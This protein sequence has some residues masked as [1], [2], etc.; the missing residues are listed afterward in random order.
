MRQWQ[1]EACRPSAGALPASCVGTPEVCHAHTSRRSSLQCCPAPRRCGRDA[2][3]RGATAIDLAHRHDAGRHPGHRRRARPGHRRHPLHGLY[4]LRPVGGMGPL[5]GHRTGEAGAG[6]RH[7]MVPGSHGPD[8]MDL[9]AAPGREIPRRLGL[10]RRRG[11]LHPRAGAQRQVASLRSPRPQ[12]A[13]RLAVAACRLSQD[14]RLQGR[15]AD[16]RRQYSDAVPAQPCADREPGQLRKGRPRLAGLPEVPVGNR[17]V[18]DEGV[19]AARARRTR[20]AFPRASAWS[21]CRSPTSRP[22]RRP[23]WP[24][25]ST[26]SRRPPPTRSTSCAPAAARSRRMP[27]RTC[28]PIR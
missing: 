16:Q 20:T 27:F 19:D 4:A 15:D 10:Q 26:G 18:E 3:R 7:Q 13:D 21:C 17:A 24:A 9:R 28:G 8:E 11:D 12:R 1:Q 5:L 14:R 6:A 22:G 25:A 23:C 2:P